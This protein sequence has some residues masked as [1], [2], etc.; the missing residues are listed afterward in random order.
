MRKC[1]VEAAALFEMSDSF[2]RA[3]AHV[4]GPSYRTC[5]RFCTPNQPVITSEPRSATRHHTPLHHAPNRIAPHDCISRLRLT[6]RV[7]HQTLA[8]A[9]LDEIRDFVMR[10]VIRIYEKA[11]LYARNASRVYK[12][13]SW[14][15]DSF[16]FMTNSRICPGFQFV[17]V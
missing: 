15:M 17:Q 12:L 2:Q 3:F 7:K 11:A 8:A 4:V 9:N 1:A 13:A 6:I 16:D 10:P 14:W 5:A